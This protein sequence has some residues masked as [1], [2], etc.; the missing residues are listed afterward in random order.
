M[1]QMNSPGR[2][3]CLRPALGGESP[4]RRLEVQGRERE[5][6]VLRPDLE[7]LAVHL[8]RI[9]GRRTRAGRTPCWRSV[10]D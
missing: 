6:H 8:R 9:G 3:V 10:T 2:R 7:G 4:L 1:G 5:L